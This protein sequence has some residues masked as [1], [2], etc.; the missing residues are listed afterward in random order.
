ML[1][2]IEGIA[3]G[4]K[5]APGQAFDGIFDDDLAAEDEKARLL[6]KQATAALFAATT[7]GI[8]PA[9]QVLP[10]QHQSGTDYSMECKDESLDDMLT[11]QRL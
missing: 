6:K 10:G 2:G 9:G 3:G 4:P 8:I 11:E 7:K 1:D 5:G